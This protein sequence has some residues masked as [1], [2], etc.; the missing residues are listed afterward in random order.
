MRHGIRMLSAIAAVSGLLLSAGCVQHESGW[1]SSYL[2]KHEDK[3]VVAMPQG[4]PSISQQFYRDPAG[5][6]HLGIDVIN[7]IGTPVLAAAGGQVTDSYFEPAYGNRITIDHGLSSNGL[8]TTT[9]YKHLNS[10]AVSSGDRV[11]RGQQI[12]TLGNT[13]ALAGGIPHLH[14]EVRREVR[15]KVFRAIDPHKVWAGGVGQVSCFDPATAD[16]PD[17]FGTTYPVPC[18]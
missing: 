11:E 4:A 5:S 17:G 12:A 8:R 6:G 9:V 2:P 10:R 15:P 18:R 14:F 16:E 7:G 1:A 3:L 13:G